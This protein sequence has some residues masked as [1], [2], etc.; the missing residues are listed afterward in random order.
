MSTLFNA[1]KYVP[2]DINMYITETTMYVSKLIGIQIDLKNSIL[3]ELTSLKTFYS[4]AKTHNIPYDVNDENELQYMIDQLQLYTNYHSF[5][6]AMLADK[7]DTLRDSYYKLQHL[8]PNTFFDN[9]LPY[10][11]EIQSLMNKR[12]QFI[13]HT[14]YFNEKIQEIKDIKDDLIF[15][16][17]KI[18]KLL[19]TLTFIMFEQA[20]LNEIIQLSCQ[21]SSLLCS[22]SH[23]HFDKLFVIHQKLVGVYCS[24]VS[25]VTF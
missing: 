16:L 12:T 6:F 4:Y 20:V 10:D 13:N 17:I 21:L 23:L 1:R 3:D 22:S 25:F 19:P 24:H 11:I 5:R 15:T 9:C 8:L 2:S 18:C 14:V 7:Q